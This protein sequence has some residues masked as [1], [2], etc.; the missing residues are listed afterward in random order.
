M[1]DG[2][3]V[4]QSFKLVDDAGRDLIE[5]TSDGRVRVGGVAIPPPIC[6]T[7]GYVFLRVHDTWPISVEYESRVRSDQTAEYGNIRVRPCPRCRRGTGYVD[8]GLFELRT[9]VARELRTRDAEGLRRMQ[10]ALHDALANRELAVGE[11]AAR[12]ERADDGLAPAA[13]WMRDRQNRMEVWTVLGVLLTM[14]GSFGRATVREGTARPGSGG[15]QQ[16]LRHVTTT[17]ARAGP[18]RRVPVPQR[19]E[20]QAVSRRS[21]RCTT[22]R[23]RRTQY[24][25]SAT[26]QASNAAPI[27]RS[28]GVSATTMS[29]TAPQVPITAQGPPRAFAA[30]AIPSRHSRA[31]GAWLTEGSRVVSPG[32]VR[33]PQVP[34]Q[35]PLRPPSSEPG[36]ADPA[37]APPGAAQPAAQLCL[38]AE[39]VEGSDGRAHG[40][41]MT[42]PTSARITRAR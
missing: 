14:I 16:L 21:A 31:P 35:R 13:G 5:L 42:A 27:R 28:A 15:R 8:Q 32:S 2:T 34:P 37:V 36:G 10:D 4:P 41:S 23:G 26:C 7:C 11:V 39:A 29:S 33:D 9:V 20:V 30:A 3:T 25:V 17:L 6:S 19:E 12:L 24:V 38:V 1:P 22:R 18:E 40:Y